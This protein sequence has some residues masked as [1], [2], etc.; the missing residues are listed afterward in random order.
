MNLVEADHIYCIAQPKLFQITLGLQINVGVTLLAILMIVIVKTQLLSI[1][2]NKSKN[3]T[4][5]K[6]STRRLN[7]L[8]IIRSIEQQLREK[9]M[10]LNKRY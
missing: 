8:I 1:H 5:A 4:T 2:L 7:D 3:L 6:K 9:Y 10:N